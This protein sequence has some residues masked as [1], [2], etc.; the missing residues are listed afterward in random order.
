MMCSSWKFSVF[1]LLALMLAFG[2]A[3]TDAEAQPLDKP[4]YRQQ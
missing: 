4:E 3:V 1:G 2:L